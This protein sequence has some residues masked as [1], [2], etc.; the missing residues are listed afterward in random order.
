MR[1][2]K[3]LHCKENVQTLK[4]IVDKKFHARSY[5]NLPNYDNRV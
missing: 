4:S 1:E 5:C 2:T 3:I